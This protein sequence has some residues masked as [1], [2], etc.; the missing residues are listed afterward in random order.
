[1]V[2][3]I[4]SSVMSV[5]NIVRTERL[6]NFFSNHGHRMKILPIRMKHVSEVEHSARDVSPEHES[7]LKT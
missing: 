1:M 6:L 4:K 7:S 2:L 3:R 5:H